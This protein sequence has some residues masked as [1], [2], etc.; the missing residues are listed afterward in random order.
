M[1]IDYPCDLDTEIERVVQYI[2]RIYYG[3]SFS[4][5]KLIDVRQGIIRV[6]IN[7]E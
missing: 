3:A 6:K 4:F 7:N 5:I 1:R 2:S